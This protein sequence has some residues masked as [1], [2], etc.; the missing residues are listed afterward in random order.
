MIYPFTIR[1]NAEYTFN[2]LTGTRTTSESISAS[3]P[4]DTFTFSLNSSQN[5]ALAL[6]GLTADADIRLFRGAS[7]NGQIERTEPI[8]SSTRAASADE[9]ISQALTPGN[10]IVEV[11]QS[12]GNTNYRLSVSTDN[13]TNT[14]NI[15]TLNHAQTFNGTIGIDNPRSVSL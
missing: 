6:T 14:F 3:H 5:V 7:L 11:S 15:G 9:L 4:T 1:R 10:Y 2:S 12:S 13:P 8:A